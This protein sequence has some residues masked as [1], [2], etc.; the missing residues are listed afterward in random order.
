MRLQGHALQERVKS[1]KPYWPGNNQLITCGGPRHQHLFEPAWKCL[2]VTRMPKPDVLN[3][4][5]KYGVCK[6]WETGYQSSR[7][8]QR[9]HNN[10]NVVHNK[11]T[12]RMAVIGSG[13]AGFYSA[14][15]VMTRIENAIVDMYEHLPTPFGLVRFGVAPDHPEV[16][17]GKSNPGSGFPSIC[18]LLLYKFPANIINQ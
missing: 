11:K 15:K 5:R 16:K 3:A 14:Y 17:V 2:P 10:H 13:P 9:R 1:T 7:L 6:Y 18:S 12:F 4:F 8:T